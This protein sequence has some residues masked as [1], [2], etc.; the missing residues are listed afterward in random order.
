MISTAP[1]R[2][3]AV[4]GSRQSDAHSWSKREKGSDMRGNP[5]VP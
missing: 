2:A 4:H 5:T 1:T 3:Y